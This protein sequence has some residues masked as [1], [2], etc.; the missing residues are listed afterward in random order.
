MLGF[1]HHTTFL[2]DTTCLGVDLSG[3]QFQQLTSGLLKA[4]LTRDIIYLIFKLVFRYLVF[5]KFGIWYL[6]FGKFGIWYLVMKP[7]YKIYIESFTSNWLSSD[8]IILQGVPKVP[9][10]FLWLFSRVSDRETL[11]RNVRQCTARR[12]KGAHEDV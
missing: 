10:N 6:V 3:C 1:I 7:D 5:F 4:T 8:L 9:L 12:G 11:Q 2:Y